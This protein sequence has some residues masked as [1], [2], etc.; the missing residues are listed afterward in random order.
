[1]EVAP[2][3]GGA[4][5]LAQCNASCK[6][7]PKHNGTPPV[8]QVRDDCWPNSPHHA[9][10]IVRI[11]DMDGTMARRPCCRGSTAAST[12]PPATSAA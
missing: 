4:L 7:P 11:A 5:H 8:L 2:G 10:L 9:V 6:E 12:S 1:M 3:T